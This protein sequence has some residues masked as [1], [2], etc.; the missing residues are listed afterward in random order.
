MAWIS[1]F[2]SVP[3]S[4]VTKASSNIV[5]TTTTSTVLRP[6]LSFLLFDSLLFYSFMSHLI[7]RDAAEFQLL[8]NLFNNLTAYPFQLHAVSFFS[9]LLLLPQLPIFNNYVLKKRG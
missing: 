9:T 4:F 1:G 3:L 5:S 2:V 6:R 7:L 8:H